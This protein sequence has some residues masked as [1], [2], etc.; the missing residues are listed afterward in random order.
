MELKTIKE[1]YGKV[2]LEHTSN[3]SNSGLSI[4]PGA[5]SSNIYDIYIS[6]I[7]MKGTR[8]KKAIN[9]MFLAN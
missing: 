3:K 9:K 2:I 6:A 4:K 1:I 8:N 5:T 7:M